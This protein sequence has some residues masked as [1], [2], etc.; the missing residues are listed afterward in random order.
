M[1][2]VFQVV[3]AL[4]AVPCLASTIPAANGQSPIVNLGYA[5]HMG[6]YNVCS[7]PR[8]FKMTVP[9]SLNFNL[10]ESAFKYAN[11]VFRIL[12][13]CIPSKTSD[14]QMLQQAMNDSTQQNQPRERIMGSMMARSDLNALKHSPSGISALL[15]RRS[16]SRRNN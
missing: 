8:S 6:L 4:S 9:G 11:H 10:H 2:L 12:N 3:V 1:L 15:Q 5:R 14:L 16:T 13:T 7:L